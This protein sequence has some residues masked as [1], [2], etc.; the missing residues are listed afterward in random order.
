[1]QMLNADQDSVMLSI[2]LLVGK[3]MCLILWQHF[4]FQDPMGRYHV[5]LPSSSNNDRQRMTVQ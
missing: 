2:S 3:C 1:M 4:A 5:V